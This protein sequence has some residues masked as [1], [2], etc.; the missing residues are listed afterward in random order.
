MRRDEHP[1]TMRR[2]AGAG[3]DQPP[4]E[5]GNRGRIFSDDSSP[6]STGGRSRRWT[7]GPPTPYN[8][9]QASGGLPFGRSGTVWFG[10]DRSVGNCG[11]QDESA[12]HSLFSPVIALPGTL[13]A[14]TLAFT[15]F[16]DTEAFYD[17]GNVKLSVDGGPWQ[18]VPHEAF[19]FNNYN[20]NLQ[21]TDN[22]N[23]LAGEGAFTG[24]ALSGGG[25]GTSLID[26]GGYVSGG[27]TLQVRF[28][29]SKDGCGGADGWYLDDF[30][31]YQCT[32]VVF[33]PEPPTVGDTACYMGLA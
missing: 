12:V 7:V 8:W 26:L 17:G 30:E 3:H 20:G 21:T 10:E 11:S 13:D 31:I 29:M 23:P 16:V 19:T 9:V 6:A 4:Q 5:C 14:P 15:H 18:L 24:S 22:T 25:W 2:C 32:D 1:W 27:E 28:D 33:N